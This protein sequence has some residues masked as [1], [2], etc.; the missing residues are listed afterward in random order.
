[1]YGLPKDPREM[2]DEEIDA[3]LAKDHPPED[4]DVQWWWDW[5]EEKI[6]FCIS[7]AYKHAISIELVQQS[8]LKL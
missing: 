3:A 5:P 2:S 8:L 7:A 6:G 4:F 1:M